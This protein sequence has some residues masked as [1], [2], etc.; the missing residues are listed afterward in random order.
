MTDIVAAAFGS[1]VTNS[2]ESIAKAMQAGLQPRLIT[3]VQAQCLA[4]IFNLDTWK[5][6]A[7][8]PAL[9]GAEDL[10]IPSEPMPAAE[11]QASRPATVAK[12]AKR[13]NGAR[14]PRKPARPHS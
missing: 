1:F 12:K 6:L 14:K 2:P 9:V 3:R 4:N 7:G 10:A 11:P 13:A 5:N 8:A